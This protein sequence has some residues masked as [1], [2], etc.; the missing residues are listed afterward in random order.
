MR[1]YT[2]QGSPSTGNGEEENSAVPLESYVFLWLY[3][4]FSTVYTKLFSLSGDTMR[5]R[6]AG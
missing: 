6:D 5:D 3:S 2:S 4:R 1:F